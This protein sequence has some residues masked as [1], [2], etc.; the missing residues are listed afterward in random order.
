MME[1]DREAEGSCPNKVIIPSPVSQASFPTQNTQKVENPS[2]R[3]WQQHSMHRL[4][5]LP[6][7][8]QKELR[9]FIQNCTMEK[10]GYPHILREG[11]Q[12]QVGID[13]DTQ[14]SEASSWWEGGVHI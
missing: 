12:T 14:K 3:T 9:P 2:R 6:I 8:R 1:D 4:K 11:Y 13:T 5:H 7:W 10:G